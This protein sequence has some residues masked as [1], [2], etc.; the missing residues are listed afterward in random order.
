MNNF[1]ANETCCCCYQCN[2][3]GRFFLTLGNFSKPVATIISPKSPHFRQFAKGI[4]IFH[5]SSEISFGSLFID[6]WR[7][8]SGHTACL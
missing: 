4:K 3:I 7:L 8:F 5:F 6:I 2:Q 1:S